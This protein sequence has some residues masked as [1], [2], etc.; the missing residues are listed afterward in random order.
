M[1]YFNSFNI[2]SLKLLV[3]GDI[4]SE[5]IEPKVE[6][7]RDISSMIDVL[8]LRLADSFDEQKKAKEVSDLISGKLNVL[9]TVTL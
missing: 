3:L 2:F 5:R 7:P 1:C 4:F 8:F 6:E 9:C